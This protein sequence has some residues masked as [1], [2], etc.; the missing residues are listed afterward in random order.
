M[1]ALIPLAI[2]TSKVLDVLRLGDSI[3]I[4]VGV[5]KRNAVFYC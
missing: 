5:Q 3:A 2:Y 4:G 1:V